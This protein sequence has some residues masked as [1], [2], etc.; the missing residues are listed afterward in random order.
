MMLYQ[1]F[2]LLNYY[3]LYGT[4]WFSKEPQQLEVLIAMACEAMFSSAQQANLANHAEGATLLQV[5][6]QCCHKV[7][8]K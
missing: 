5:I 8:T 4:E 1:L 3:C 7:M 2:P 6:V